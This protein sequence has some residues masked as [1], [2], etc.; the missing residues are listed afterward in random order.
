M[1]LLSRRENTVIV[2]CKFVLLDKNTN[3][4]ENPLL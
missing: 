1:V 2:T 3:A 4:D